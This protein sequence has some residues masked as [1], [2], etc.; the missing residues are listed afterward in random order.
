MCAAVHCNYASQRVPVLRMGPDI[1]MNIGPGVSIFMGP[2]IFMTSCGR[3]ALALAICLAPNRLTWYHTDDIQPE[4]N[5]Y[6]RSD[7]PGMRFTS[8]QICIYHVNKSYCKPAVY[9]VTDTVDSEEGRRD[10]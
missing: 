4:E 6:S 5:V 9:M 1:Y 10:G 3:S 2:Q 8:K 7:P